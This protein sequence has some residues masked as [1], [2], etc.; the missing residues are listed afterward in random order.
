MGDPRHVPGQPFDRGTSLRAGLFPRQPNQQYSATLQPRIL[1]FC[2]FNDPFCDSGL[3]L[4]VHLTYLDRD[5]NTAAEFI[6][7]QI[8]G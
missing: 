5:Q 6:L 1:S 7:T 8:G 2:D 4:T 3:D